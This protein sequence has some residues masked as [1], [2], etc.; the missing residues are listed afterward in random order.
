M[1]SRKSA[2]VRARSINAHLERFIEDG[3]TVIPQVFSVDET[4]RVLTGNERKVARA[5]A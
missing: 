3:Y 5:R 2:S 1:T 4:G